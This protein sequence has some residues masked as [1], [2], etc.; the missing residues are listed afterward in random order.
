MDGI[1]PWAELVLDG[2]GNLYGTTIAGGTS[3]TACGGSGCGTLFEL[4]ANSNGSWS[5]IVLHNFSEDGNDGWRPQAG[6][7]FD[8]AGNL[9]GTTYGGGR[10]KGGTV[11]E[12]APGSNGTWVETILHSFCNSGSCKSNGLLPIANVVFGKKG[13]LYGTTSAGGFR[14]HPCG[15]EGCGVV[16]Q[17]KPSSGGKWRETVLYEFTTP[18]LS[19]PGVILD[20]EGNLFGTTPYTAFQLTKKNG[21]AE[22]TLHTFGKDKDGSA[23]WAALTFDAGGNLY[24]TTLSGGDFNSGTVFRLTPGKNGKWTEKILHSF[25]NNH[26]DG[27]WPLAGVVFDPSGNLYG[28]TVAGGTGPCKNSAGVVI[29]CGTVFEITP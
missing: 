9:Y 25:N 8:S 13:S 10:L 16:F 21:W 2:A 28:T 17:L 5:E 27:M 22:K 14:R 12:L 20:V 15:N 18:A 23:L 7:T 26:K 24:S 6:L 3:G 19:T 1:A 4:S 11:F 29:G